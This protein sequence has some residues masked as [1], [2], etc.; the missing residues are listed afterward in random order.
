MRNFLESI[1]R[2]DVSCDQ[3]ANKYFFRECW[4]DSN[5]TPTLKKFCNRLSKCYCWSTDYMMALRF[6]SRS[7][8]IIISHPE[9]HHSD[10][11]SARNVLRVANSIYSHFLTC[12]LLFLASSWNLIKS[13]THTI[14]A[15]G[16][17]IQK[18]RNNS[19]MMRGAVKRGVRR[20]HTLAAYSCHAGHKH[21]SHTPESQSERAR[22][23][24]VAPWR[25]RPAPASRRL[26]IH[27]VA[28][29]SISR[30]G[31]KSNASAGLFANLH[32]LSLCGRRCLN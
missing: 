11:S 5:L 10:S 23:A 1:L 30:G 21:I 14:H 12:P 20:G 29:G 22:G 4:H 24:R 28:A 26:L 31:C 32:T 13:R 3:K 7:T 17:H 16:A 18:A 27:I 6:F 25:R 9:Y 2:S 8:S 19:L 15:C